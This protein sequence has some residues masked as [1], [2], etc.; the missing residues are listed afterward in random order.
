MESNISNWHQK[1]NAPLKPLCQEGNRANPKHYAFL[2][3]L[4]FSFSPS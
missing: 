2:L 3:E 4:E 1:R